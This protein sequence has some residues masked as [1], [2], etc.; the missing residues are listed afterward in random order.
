MTSEALPA[1]ALPWITIAAMAGVTYLTRIAGY[2]ALARVP[3]GGLLRRVLDQV[4]GATFAALVA[5]RLAVA[6]PEEWL[7]A[8]VLAVA[9][10]RGGPLA[11][12][13]GYVGTLSLLRALGV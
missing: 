7:A 3:D 13:L 1:D 12:I 8:V 11:A 6:P 10:W 5:P 4:P 9:L 2:L